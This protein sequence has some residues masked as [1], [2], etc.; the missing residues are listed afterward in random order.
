MKA[1]L[2]WGLIGASTIARE[3]MVDAIN[4][5]PDSQVVNIMSSSPVRAQQFART[6]HIA[7][8]CTTL[9]E[10][11]ADPAIDVV[12]ISTTNELHKEQT[13]AAAHALHEL[14]VNLADQAD[15]DGQF[16]QAFEA[17][18]KRHRGR[19]RVDWIRTG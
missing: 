15:G 3:W 13:L 14:R 8:H 17:E 10:F 7:R 1:K 6:H 19:A 11:L 5:Q 16:A 18:V 12:Y 4:A 9:D 2:G